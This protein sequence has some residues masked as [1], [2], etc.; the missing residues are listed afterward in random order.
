MYAIRS[1][2]VSTEARKALRQLIGDMD[3]ALATAFRDGADATALAARRGE[4]VGRIVV[5]VWNACL[6]EVA[7][8]AL[9]AVGGFGRGLLFP[10]SDVDP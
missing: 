6:G 3:R 2:Y 10:Q 8:T 7:D 1:Y 9:F 4:S 5:H